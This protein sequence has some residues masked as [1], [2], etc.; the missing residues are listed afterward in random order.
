MLKYREE[1]YVLTQNYTVKHGK[2]KKI[3]GRVY[4]AGE[5]MEEGM[6]YEGKKVRLWEFDIRQLGS[7]QGQPK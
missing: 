5:I 3:S 4:N 6:Y 7:S 2:Y 1:F